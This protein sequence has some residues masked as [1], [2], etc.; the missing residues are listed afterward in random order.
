MSFFIILT[1]FCI[2]KSLKHNKYSIIWDSLALMAAVVNTAV[3]SQT[4]PIL[5]L[6]W[7][8]LLY[9]HWKSRSYL[10]KITGIGLL[11]G[12]CVYLP[13]LLK[14]V[15]LTFYALFWPFFSRN[16]LICVSD[17]PRYELSN[18]LEFLIISVKDYGLL[19]IIILCATL[20]LKKIARKGHQ[21]FLLLSISIVL[22]FVLTALIHHPLDSAYLYPVVPVLSIL[23]SYYFLSIINNVKP[24]SVKI[25]FI[26]S[27]FFFYS[28]ILLHFP[29]IN[30]SK[31]R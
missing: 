6:I 14:S 1:I 16:I 20:T 23:A 24:Y 27:F 3:R 11:A 13:F 26:Y 22:L 10:V 29:I 8:Y 30:F 25:F 12:I 15:Q 4:I 17:I 18:I 9:V 31:L 28:Q 7:F 2:T 19:F 21:I 5:F